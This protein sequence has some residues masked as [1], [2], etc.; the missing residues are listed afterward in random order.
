MPRDIDR[1]VDQIKADLT[2]LINWRD[3]FLKAVDDLS[4]L[5]VSINNMLERT[6]IAISSLPT[7]ARFGRNMK[8][9]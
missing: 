3:R 8:I 7:V 5:L 2:E 1:P 6:L 9:S 4:V